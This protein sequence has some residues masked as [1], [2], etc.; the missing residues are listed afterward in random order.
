MKF[1][2]SVPKESC[3]MKPFRI[4]N[5]ETMNVPSLELVTECIDVPKEVCAM[6]KGNPRKI[7]RPI[8]KLW[9]GQT[10]KPSTKSGKLPQAPR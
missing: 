1:V 5:N 8:V 9:C 6:E 7:K 10:E 3:S 4:C 2:T